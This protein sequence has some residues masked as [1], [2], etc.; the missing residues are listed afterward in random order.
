MSLVAIVWGGGSCQ[1]GYIH[2]AHVSNYKSPDP[3]LLNEHCDG[4]S[5]YELDMVG[6]KLFE[7]PKREDI[8]DPKNSKYGREPEPY[9]KKVCE[10]W[11]INNGYQV[12]KYVKMRTN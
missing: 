11:C 8:T 7:P 2:W 10:E 1:L 4:I 12:F 3:K 6:E 5:M 9:P